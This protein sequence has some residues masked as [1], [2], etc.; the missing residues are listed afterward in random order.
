[1]GRLRRSSPTIEQAEA[2]ANGLKSKD[3]EFDLGNGITAAAFDRLIAATRAKLET[4][5]QTLATADDQQNELH[6]AE[7]ALKDMS[8][9]VL[10]AVKAK[11]GPDSTEYE[12]AGGTRTSERKRAPRKPSTPKP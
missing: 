6:A 11:Y 2:R 5:N 8:G 9:R 7:Q 10:A 1:M 12:L 3:K 4:Y